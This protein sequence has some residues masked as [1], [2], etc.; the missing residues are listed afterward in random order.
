MTQTRTL[1][2]H[3]C[4]PNERDLV[5]R[6]L[7]A[8]DAFHRARRLAERTERVAGRSREM[9]LDAS[10][11]LDVLRRE[12]DALVARSQQ[13]LTSSLRKAPPG[14]RVVLAHRNEWFVGVVAD[15]VR[16]RGLDVV[17]EL[18]NGA[19]AVGTVVAEQP[20]LLLVE[21]ALAMLPGEQVVREVVKF[22]PSTLVVAQ[23]AYGDRV[24][25][26]LDAGADAVVTRQV[27][28]REVAQKMCELVSA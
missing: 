23:V 17:A 19:D 16:A 11:R 8:V 13:Q 24:G 25:D 2:D 18:D 4:P 15:L 14:C 7:E 22:S 5:A 27:P 21:D 26:L 1:A 12:H 3:W 20:D 28:P 6:Q 9:R 10:R